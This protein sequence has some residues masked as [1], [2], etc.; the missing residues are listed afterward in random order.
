MERAEPESPLTYLQLARQLV[1]KQ[2][3]SKLHEVK[4]LTEVR[5]GLDKM[6]DTVAATY[7]IPGIPSS[8]T[9]HDAPALPT[10]SS[11]SLPGAA[12]PTVSV[13]V[14][15]N[16]LDT[17]SDSDE[18]VVPPA[19]RQRTGALYDSKKELVTPP[20]M[21]LILGSS[22]FMT[23]PLV[24]KL[25]EQVFRCELPS[26]E[27]DNRITYQG[28]KSLMGFELWSYRV[29]GADSGEATGLTFFTRS[30]FQYT[31]MRQNVLHRLGLNRAPHQPIP[32]PLLCYHLLMLVCIPVNQLSGHL[33]G[34][35]F[36]KVTGQE[37]GS[38]Q[39]VTKD[40]IQQQT[41][42]EICSMVRTWAYNLS[43]FIAR[44][45]HEVEA[46]SMLVRCHNAFMRKCDER[47]NSPT[48]SDPTV[49]I[50]REMLDAD[51]CYSQI[52]LGINVKELR[53]AIPR[54]PF[55]E[56]AGETAEE[57]DQ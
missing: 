52:Y 19:K 43:Q 46:V 25:Y 16:S 51:E 10:S 33:L 7:A 54:L 1:S 36:N 27:Y 22:F 57:I 24:F 8:C 37:L 31:A 17:T 38:L 45:G 44:H 21:H 29:E 53:T 9:T 30:S 18:T 11:D 49:R 41:D 23:L 39:V 14:P 2:I 20:R 34:E 42:D 6:I 40:S 35:L 4:G 26:D 56:A 28:L 48:Y 32:S 50:M 5:D 15:V 12:R 13:P 47:S 55:I 3:E